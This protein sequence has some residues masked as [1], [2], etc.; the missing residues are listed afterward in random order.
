MAYVSGRR[1]ASGVLPCLGAM[2][3]VVG[4]FFGYIL[5]FDDPFSLFMGNSFLAIG[6]GMILIGIAI[7]P[8]GAREA[9]RIRSILEIAAVRKEVTI[10]DIS[11]E[12][13][14]DREYIRKVITDLL[15]ANMLFGYL[16]DDLFV[17]D[18]SGRPPFYGAGRFGL[19]GVSG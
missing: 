16:E 10:S 14:L 8:S 3:C 9:K 2:L 17:R 1:I 6:A 12:T 19:G 7:Y 13:G 15:I 18:T 4:F 11:A 5:P